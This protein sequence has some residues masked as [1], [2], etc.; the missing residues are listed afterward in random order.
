MWL[1]GEYLEFNLSKSFRFHRFIEKNGRVVRRK[2]DS[3]HEV[4]V[5][6]R[7]VQGW[8]CDNTWLLHWRYSPNTPKSFAS[9]NF[10]TFYS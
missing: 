1:C 4:L 6:N 2:I 5:M 9:F 10:A 3:F 7:S 8:K